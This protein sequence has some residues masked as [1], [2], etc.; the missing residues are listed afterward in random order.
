MLRRGSAPAAGIYVEEEISPR[1]ADQ[2]ERE[3]ADEVLDS[4]RWSR[5]ELLY[6]RV[7]LIRGPDGSPRLVELELTE[8]SLFLSYGKGAAGR[9]AD[10]IVSR[11]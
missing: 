2:A 4:L 1:E 7:D 5:A 8:P 3:I 11:L 10:E 9:L 6:A